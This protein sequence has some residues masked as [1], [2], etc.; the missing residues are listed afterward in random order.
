MISSIEKLNVKQ[1]LLELSSIDNVINEVE[2]LQIECCDNSKR[3]LRKLRWTKQYFKLM[4]VETTNEASLYITC[5]TNWDMAS[6][7]DRHFYMKLEGLHN[8]GKWQIWVCENSKEGN[9]CA[10]LRLT[11]ERAKWALQN[12]SS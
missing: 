7:E 5:C 9:K 3:T 11:I 12:G 4:N 8:S 6:S 10:E 2:M 1:Q